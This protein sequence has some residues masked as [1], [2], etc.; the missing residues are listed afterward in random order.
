MRRILSNPLT[1]LLVCP[2]LRLFFVLKFPAGSG[3][4]T[5]YEQLAKNWLKHGKYAM[6]IGGAAI[7][8]DLRV[9]GY[10]AFLALVYMLTGRTGEP[11]RLFVMLAQVLVDLMTCA[12]TGAL[13][14][15]LVT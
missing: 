11:A 9:P 15:L 14:A 8:V 13:A 12:V 10:P 2:C 6:D 1:A 4:T 7:P 3:D 5:I